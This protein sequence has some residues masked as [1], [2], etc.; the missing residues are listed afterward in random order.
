MAAFSRTCCGHSWLAHEGV[1]VLSTFLLVNPAAGQ[2]RAAGLIPAARFALESIGGATVLE[3][4]GSGDEAIC[5]RE[6]LQQGA[7]TIVVLGGDGTVSQVA[8]AMIRTGTRVPLAILGAGTGNDFARSLGAPVHDFGAMARLI[9]ARAI[10]C[11]DAGR[12]DDCFFVNSAGFGF[13]VEVLQHMFR[14]GQSGGTSAYALAALRLL[15]RYPGFDAEVAV[16]PH[17]E[18]H[19]V[20][21]AE[22]PERNINSGQW[23]TL[24]FANGGWFG[25]AFNIAPHASIA[26]GLLDYVAIRNTSPTRR[27]LL[28]ARAVRGVHVGQREVTVQRHSKWTLGFRESPV[29]QLDG[30]LRQALG[31]TVE[32]NAVPQA[33]CVITQASTSPQPPQH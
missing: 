9:A 5:A 24:V 22:R 18:L 33:L 7:S 15:F 23:L 3:T 27:A 31:T 25:G 1:V 28:F 26:D 10:R 11:V 17:C 21:G 2:G 8:A 6:A 16:G 20:P 30:E 12:V 19:R 29:Y 32:I 13:D 4:R 14:T